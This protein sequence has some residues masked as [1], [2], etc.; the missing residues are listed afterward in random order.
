[1]R[2]GLQDL[3][4]CSAGDRATLVEEDELVGVPADEVQV[5]QRYKRCQRQAAHECED[6]VL[7]EDVEMAFRDVHRSQLK[8]P[9]GLATLRAWR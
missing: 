2:S 7:V 4:R 3:I 8:P 5:V 9:Y 1:M 6:L